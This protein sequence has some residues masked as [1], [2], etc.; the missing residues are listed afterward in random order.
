MIKTLVNSR[1]FHGLLILA[2]ISNLG[3]PNGPTRMRAL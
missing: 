1:G 3:I 2:E